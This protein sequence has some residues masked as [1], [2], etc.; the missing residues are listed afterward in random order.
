[1]VIDL[2]SRRALVC[3]ST[4]GIGWAIAQGL[5]AAG[6]DVVLAARDAAKLAACSS[7][8]QAQY[9]QVSGETLAVDF[10]RPEAVAQAIAR[11]LTQHSY[12]DILVNNSGGPPGGAITNAQLTAFEAAFARLLFSGHV[13]V[14]ALVPEMKA[15]KWGRIL[16]VVSTSVYEPLK[17]LG[18]SNT[19][20]AAVAGWAKTLSK[21]L[22]A[23]GITVN[24]ILPGATATQRLSS[25]I[26]KKSSETGTSPQAIEDHMLGE[27][28][29]G[30]FGKPEEIAALAVFLASPQAAYI[31]GTSIPV[32]GGRMAKI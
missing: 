13:L 24:N 16:N 8:L 12:F 7:S 15:R 5:A 14:Q 19:T 31:T 21:E 30:R 32:D 28:P 29:M 26:E 11:H 23:E 4:Q 1:M 18:V 6:A 17:G 2:R 10:D 22:A 3:G 9:P 25:L 27:I 20:R